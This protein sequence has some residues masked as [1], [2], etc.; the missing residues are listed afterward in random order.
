MFS[1]KSIVAALL[2]LSLLTGAGALQAAVMEKLL[3]GRWMMYAGGGADTWDFHADGTCTDTWYSGKTGT[4]TWRVEPAT[5]ADLEKLWARPR[6]VLV[7]DEADRYGLHLEQEQ[8][9]TAL[10][11]LRGGVIT[12][13]ERALTASIPLCIAITHGIGGGGYV[14]MKDE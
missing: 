12:D 6:L 8:L 10:D 5:E 4:H 9:F 2:I 7:I 3:P 11:I 13:A 1:M 14:R